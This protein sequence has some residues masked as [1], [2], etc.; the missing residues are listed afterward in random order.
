MSSKLLL[1][2]E[3]VKS[4]ALH[5]ENSKNLSL[6]PGRDDCEWFGFFLAS[7][8]HLRKLYK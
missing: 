8:A 1:G 3:P 7:G 5:Y 4:I 6:R 2:L